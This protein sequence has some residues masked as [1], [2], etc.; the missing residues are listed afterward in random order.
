MKNKKI[1]LGLLTVGAL[2][3]LAACGTDKKGTTATSANK[4]E[5]SSQ[6][7]AQADLSKGQ[8]L[9]D[10]LTNT[11]WQGTV[12]YD[13]NKEDLTKENAGFIGLAKYD[14]ATNFYEFFDKE[15]GETRGD[16]GTFFITEDGDK[17][18]LISATKEYQAVV[19]ITELTEDLFTYKRMG[20]DKDG[21]PVEVFVEHVPYDKKLTFTN[22]RDELTSTTGTIETDR[23]GTTILSETLWN[24]TKVLDE[25][26]ND[27][28]EENKMFISLAKF[29]GDN[30]K[31]EFFNLETGETRGDFGYYDVVANNKI[32]TH[33]SIGEN[34]YG[35]VLE[36]TEINDGKFTYKRMGKNAKDEDVVVF[37]EHEPY[38]GEF[39]P[40]FTF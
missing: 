7:E 34:K 10:I 4:T 33:V 40:E 12:V 28:T 19:T 6:V 11:N 17:R 27:L 21:N 22:G 16:E 20:E 24:G 18:I 36:I 39:T 14:S 37:V 31:Y 15:T 32:R 26:G 8:E 13:Q 1:V 35:A 29:A 30:S 5:A 3:L 38:K 9:T 23:P 2:C 25:A